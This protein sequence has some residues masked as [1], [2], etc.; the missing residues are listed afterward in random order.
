ML[1]DDRITAGV[2]WRGIGP[3]A[4]RPG[5]GAPYIVNDHGDRQV[6][7][8]TTEAFYDKIQSDEN[9][10][11]LRSI[12]LSVFVAEL[13]ESPSA[14]RALLWA[15]GR[16]TIEALAG[17]HVSDILRSTARVSHGGPTSA[18][19]VTMPMMVVV[20]DPSTEVNPVTNIAVYLE[21]H[22]VVQ[23]DPLW[24]TS[25]KPLQA[26]KM[27]LAGLATEYHRQAGWVLTPG[28]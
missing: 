9:N 5:S 8:F 24:V 26:M 27:A 18:G 1:R 4:A 7:S 22:A 28:A 15:S 20:Y 12:Q 10:P 13:A 17:L 16:A 21:A 19:G 2:V 25:R 11:K 3:Q 23:P 6:I 14:A